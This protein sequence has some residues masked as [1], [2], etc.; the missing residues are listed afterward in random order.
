MTDTRPD[1]TPGRVITFGV[2]CNDR[3]Y[4]ILGFLQHERR[5]VVCEEKKNQINVIQ[6]LI[7]GRN[8]TWGSKPKWVKH[9]RP[10]PRGKCLYCSVNPEKLAA[11]RT[12]G[13]IVGRDGEIP[14]PKS[15]WTVSRP[16]HYAQTKTVIFTRARRD[17]YCVER[18]GTSKGR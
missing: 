2:Y 3:R 12:L 7:I 11:D 15:Y 8:G 5:F 14:W 16:I 1:I 13:N 4:R 9:P 10:Q 17:G 6:F 18:I